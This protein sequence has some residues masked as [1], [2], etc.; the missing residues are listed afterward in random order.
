MHPFHITR[1]LYLLNGTE[2]GVTKARGTFKLHEGYSKIA[3]LPMCG[4]CNNNKPNKFHLIDVM[5]SNEID[6]TRRKRID[7]MRPHIPVGF[8][9]NYMRL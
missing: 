9:M 5:N 3:L 6:S 2:V 1:T 8:I 4:Q 7:S